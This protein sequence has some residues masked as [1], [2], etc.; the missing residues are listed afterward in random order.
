MYVHHTI[1]SSAH[2]QCVHCEAGY[3]YIDLTIEL[4]EE[5]WYVHNTIH[6]QPLFPMGLLI[7]LWS[8]L[9]TVP[10]LHSY[11]HPSPFVSLCSIVEVSQKTPI[12]HFT[13]KCIDTQQCL[14]LFCNACAYIQCN[15]Y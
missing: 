9:S 14:C 7:L 10:P 11:A 13:C 2:V 3:M 15:P 6:A 5:C 4:G 8:S 1:E 12:G